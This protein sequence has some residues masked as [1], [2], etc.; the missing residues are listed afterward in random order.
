MLGL[1]FDNEILKFSQSLDTIL[2]PYSLTSLKLL[3][4]VG[5][6]VVIYFL[7]SVLYALLERVIL[8]IDAIEHY[9]RDIL[10]AIRGAVSLLM[11]VANLHFI[12][13]IYNDF[14][15]PQTILALFKIIYTLLLTFM[16]YRFVNTTAKVKL[17]SF[18]AS[19]VKMKKDLINVGIKILNSLIMLV[20]LLFVLFFWGVDLTA[21]LSGLG[22]GG[23]AVAFA[24][25]DTISNFFGTLS[26]LVSDVFSQGDWIEVNSQEGVVVEIGLRVTTLRTFD[27]ALISIPNGTVANADVKNWSKRTL[28]RRIMMKIGVKYD[29]KAQDIKNAVSQIYHMLDKHTGIATENTRYEHSNASFAKIVSKDDLEG[30]KKTLMVH[31]DE[32]AP[33]SINI[34]IYCFTKTVLWD[35]W[36]AIK[37]DVMYKIME[38]LEQNNLS[39]AFPSLSLYTQES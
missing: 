33:L 10:D 29:S 35:E 5:A 7:R 39:F 25:K 18:G 38:I 12:V 15:T 11:L 37:E 24:A 31:V 28:G 2:V 32:F 36:L 20:G 19:D 9:S 14:N 3:F 23:I 17:S 1:S 8:K 27:N 4:M 26:I 30:V 21:V 22:I 13:Y 16:L 34:L 6:V